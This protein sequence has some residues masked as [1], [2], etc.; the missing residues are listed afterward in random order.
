L[1]VGIPLA[2]RCPWLMRS[3]EVMLAS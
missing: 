3:H 2:R 1:L